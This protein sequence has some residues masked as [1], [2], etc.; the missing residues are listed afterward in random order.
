MVSKYKL[1]NNLLGWMVCVIACSVYIFTAEPTVSFWDCGEYIA[2]AYKLQV[3]HPP[4]APTFQLFGRIFTMFA[5][6][7]V[8]KVAF[9]INTM[10]ALCSGFT[11]LFLFWSITIFTKKLALSKPGSELT[12]S[13]TIAIFGSGLV[14]AL[15]YTFTDT[16]WFSAVEGEV[17][18]MSSFFTALVFWAILKWESIADKNYSYRWIILIAFLI[19]LSIGVHLLNLLTVTA[20]VLVIYFKKYT[21][22][23]KGMIYAILISFVVIGF[24]MWGLVPG[25]VKYSSVFERMFVNSFKL[26]FNVGTIFYF[27]VIAALLVWGL[28]YSEKR[29]KKLLNIILLSLTFIIIGYSTFF[30]LVI[31]SNANTPI[32]ENNPEDAVAL[33]SYLNREQYGS[34]PL[35]Y[36]EYYNSPILRAEDGKPVYVKNYVVRYND[37]PVGSF[38]HK[39]DAENFMKENASKYN[40]MNMRGE[41]VIGDPKKNTKYIF[42]GNYC[43][44]FPRMWNREGARINQY[45]QWAGITEDY[46]Y[47]NGQQVPRK[48]SFGE[49]LRFFFRY[50]LGYMY[51]RYFMWNF[52]G[53]QNINQGFGGKTSGAWISG[54]SFIDEARLG[55]QDV[56]EHMKTNG[57]NTYFFLPLI[58]G[59]I[60]MIFQF[61]K[62][63]PNAF[64][65]LCLFLMTGIAISVYLNMYAYQP[66][67]RDYAFAASFFAFSMWIGLGVYSIYE[68]IKKY[69]NKTAAA[70]VSTTVCLSVPSLLAAQNW[71]DHNRSNRFLTKDIAKAYLDSCAPNAIL[72]ANGDNDTFPLWY[73]QEVEG[74]RTDVRICNLSLMGTDWYI[75][76]MKRQAYDGLPVPMKMTKEMYQMG[77]R[78][79]L[80]ALNVIKEPQDLSKVMNNIMYNPNN[81]VREPRINTITFSLPV[82]KDIVLRNGTVHL[83]DSARI[84]NQLIWRMPNENIYQVNGNDTVMVV[85]KAYI[86]MMDILANNNWER[87]IYYVSTTGSES[88]FGLDKYFQVEGLAYRLVPVEPYTTEQ[89][90]FF[91]GSVNTDI[92]YNNII[93]KFNFS[94]FSNPNIYLSEDYT[95]TVQNL[96]IFLFRLAESLVLEN[97]LARADEVMEKYYSWF[98]QQTIPYDFLD[99]YM[100]ETYIKF[101]NKEGITKGIN[102]YNDYVDQLNIETEYY[103][104]FRGKHTEIVSNNLNRNRSILNQIAN[105]SSHYASTYTDFAE[106]FNSLSE[107]ARI[108]L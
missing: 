82:D 4:G 67:E 47:I 104:K 36:G 25:I 3:G 55:P 22:S 83:K 56:P 84:V 108:H 10:S 58:L 103:L 31:R 86:A 70:I 41:Y 40:N 29:K 101:A 51:G 71:D 18:A 79:M 5:G 13:K 24:I 34:N 96:K 98:P 89:R 20:M 85:S 62:D 95:R 66:R 59:L 17:Y 23:T 42:D 100:A 50:Q 45:K 65:I 1:I 88:F 6:D 105:N 94:E 33:L 72:F 16:F 26:P 27:L 37:Y 75:D 30:I 43:T 107:K 93:K 74:Y 48:P 97:D 11:I 54:I 102:I 63:F 78:D 38:F 28:I 76:Q 32:D 60:G 106:K 61:R 2:T 19:G 53:R 91:Y 7:D 57:R 87:P 12:I 77:R 52:V 92:L 44:I 73:L 21:P 8:T 15:A 9:C 46:E 64:I 68:M 69:F 14:G 39:I 80:V 99:F 49:N 81:N 35:V 90:G